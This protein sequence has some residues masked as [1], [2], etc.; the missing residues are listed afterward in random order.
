MSAPRSTLRR[1]LARIIV[2]SV[3]TL[4]GFCLAEIATRIAWRKEAIL[5]PRY[6]T[7][8]TYGQYRIRRLRPNTT[9]HH[10]SADGRWTFAT[11]SQGYRDTREWNYARTPGVRRV[12]VLGDSH[13]QGFECRQDHTYSAV[14]EKRLR[15]MGQPTEVYNCGVSGFGTAEELALLENEGLK[16][17]PDAVVVGWFANDLNDNVNAGLFAVREGKL[18]E[19]KHEHLPGVRVLNALNKCA[20]MR[21]LSEDSYFYSLLFNRV[22]EWRRG[23]NW[24]RSN[25]AAV[26]MASAAPA[27]DPRLLGYQQD[28]AERLLS[29]MQETCAKAGVRLIVV[30]IP[31]WKAIDDFES[32]IPPAVLSEV[33]SHQVEVLT[34]EAALGRYRGVAEIFVAHGQHHISEMAHLQIAMA[35]ADLMRVP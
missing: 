22:W 6:H 35:L 5:F 12:L 27:N 32:S 20:V 9:F 14:L 2:L 7:D 24:Q 31:S 11:N 28:L 30:D 23:L 4:I 19:E 17:K 18:I 26:E 3:A 15:A 13:T 10:T 16:Y 34:S 8:A 29:R 25:A 33:Q 1:W 21:W